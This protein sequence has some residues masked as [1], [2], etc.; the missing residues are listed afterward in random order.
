MLT[1]CL[2]CMHQYESTFGLCPYC[3]YLP[4]TPAEE[5]IHMQPGI[6]LHG[7]YTVG[8]VLGFGG[9]G[10]TYIAWDNKL[11]QTVAIK[12]YLPGEFSTR[13]PGHSQISVFSGDKAEQ[14]ADGMHQFVE[15]AR[16]L[17]KF[18]DEPGI[19]TVYD[20]FEENNTAYIVMEYLEGE[21]LTAYLAR[22][23]KVQEDEAVAMLLP[24][25]NSLQAVHEAG[26]LHRD[27]APDNIFLTSDGQVKL[28]DF[29]AARYATTSHSRSLT[30]IIKPGYSP[31]EQYRSRGD[32]GPHTDVYALGAVL[33]KMITGVTPPDAMERRTKYE[34]QN[35]DILVPPQKYAQ[36]LSVAR[37]NA[38][39][40]AMNVRIEDRT[41]DVA[42]FVKELNADPPAKRIYGKIK[43]I[44]VYAWPLWLK[45]VL[46][47]L[48]VALLTLGALMLTGVIRFNSRYTEEIVLPENVVRVPEVEGLTSAE[49]SALIKEGRLLP[50]SGGNVQSEYVAAG[51]IILQTPAPGAFAPVNSQVKVVVSAGTGVIPPFNG[52]ATV[53]YIIWDTLEDAQAKL[54]EA[55]LGE[56]IVQEEYDD[57]VAA[58]QVISADRE[59]GEELP[60]GTVL[61]IILS[62]GP[63]PFALRNVVG[64]TEDAARAALES[65]GLIA[66]T[67]Y[68]N[69][70][71]IPE[72]QVISQDI[73]E[74][75]MVRKGDTVTL[76]ISSG[77]PS[78]VVENVVGKKKSE[79]K[80]TLEGQ[81]FEV[82]FLENY[83]DQVAS[84]RVISQDPEAG[85]SQ[86]EGTKITVYISKGKQKMTLHFDATGGNVAEKERELSVGDEYGELPVPTRSGFTFEGWYNAKEGGT[87][88]EAGMK[89]GAADVTLYARWEVIP[90]TEAPTVPPTL[91]VVTTE[92]P[93]T[94]A[95]TQPTPTTT[96]PVATTQAPTTQAPTTKAP[97]TKAPTT[98]APTTTV[99]PTTSV[100]KHT[101]TFDANGGS[102]SESSRKVKEGSAYG[103]LPTP[104]RDGYTFD[105]WFTAAEGGDQVSSSTTMGSKNRTIYAH[106]TYIPKKYTLTFDPNGGN[107]G[108]TNRKVKEGASYGDLPTP[109]RDGYTFDGWFTAAEDGEQVSS[110]TKMGNQNKTIYAHWTRNQTITYQVGDIITFGNYGGDPIEWQV[111]AIDGRKLLVISDWGIDAQPYNTTFEDVTWETCTL[112]NWL[113]GSFYNSAFSEAEKSKIQTTK[114]KNEDNPDYGTPGGNNTKDKVFLLS[115]SEAR[116]Y[117]GSDSARICYP[118]DYAISRGVWLAAGGSCGW[119]LRS[120]GILLGEAALID[121]AGYIDTDGD[122]GVNFSHWMVRPVLWYDP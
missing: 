122:W 34:T 93:T 12:E 25:M 11:E 24:L 109:T 49:A 44:D 80:K 5:A 75:T 39:L 17:A 35:K 72:G 16:R 26:I 84:G 95:S 99:P 86:L 58:G 57:T 96:L 13:M 3:G 54:N 59:V 85:T 47:I 90:T 9:F 78:F 43:K 79:A 105:G 14:F 70:S 71:S 121:C 52:V 42:T 48:G 104:T 120:P 15:E 23:G 106:W 19:V 8:K 51:V 66:G 7:R 94:L 98:T 45:I 31:E 116:R 112:R 50:S 40:N 81:G 107:V 28:I 108:E 87:L 118:T 111:L 37:R 89:A 69:D 92:A 102:V 119:W 74:G 55:G 64:M 115:I 62:K 103:E 56:P 88:A 91:P 77:K 29:G 4:G 101:L 63:A 60:E 18:Q 38:I 117:F 97:T 65:D 61:T 100:P 21:T 32:Q 68:V 33:Y 46:P 6:L 73:V 36:G 10:V 27:I 53:P 67:S 22:E 20:S 110:S 82:L 83:D 41:P 30:V 2:S 1:R 113:N 114:V 76:T